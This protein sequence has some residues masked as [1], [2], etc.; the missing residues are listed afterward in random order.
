MRNRDR[1]RQ[2][3]QEDERA[4]E[5]RDED[6]LAIRVVGGDLR[7]QLA[8]TGTELLPGEV[9]LSDPGIRRLY[10]ARFSLYLCERRS[11]SRRV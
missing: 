8:D 7:A 3:G 2:I 10:E 9:D 4:L 6:G 5:D 11:K 1:P